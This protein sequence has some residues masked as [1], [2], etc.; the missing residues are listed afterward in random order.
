MDVYKVDQTVGQGLGQ[1]PLPDKT[2]PTVTFDAGSDF[3]LSFFDSTDDR[4]ST[5]G[6]SDPGSVG[7]APA[8]SPPPPQTAAPLLRL[9]PSSSSSN[10]SGTTSVLGL[11]LLFQ[12]TSNGN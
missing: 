4:E 10:K 12:L 7:S 6:F 8:L 11:S 9:Q 1:P 3:N 2:Q 5:Q